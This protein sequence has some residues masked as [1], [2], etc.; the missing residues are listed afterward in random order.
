MHCSDEE[1]L[2]NNDKACLHIETCRDCHQRLLQLKKLKADAE[3]LTLYQPS[4][5][6]WNKVKA[7]IPQKKKR[8]SFIFP[9]SLAASVIVSVIL[10]L[11]IN[12]QWQD[13]KIEQLI[14]ESNSYEQQLVKME[15]PNSLVGNNLWKISQIDIQLNLKQSKE[16]QKKL[17]Q[18]RNETLKQV[19][20][21]FETEI[22]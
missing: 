19:L 5:F 15:L 11:F 16:L 9:V 18:K 7:S 2:I 1:L 14:A 22:I 6:A 21:T 12:S 3:S 4:E 10:T 17:W 20:T 13:H 8:H